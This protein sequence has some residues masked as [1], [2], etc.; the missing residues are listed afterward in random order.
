VGGCME[1]W[2]VKCEGG[3]VG[4]WMDYT[5]MDN[6][7]PVNHILKRPIVSDTEN[8]DSTMNSSVYYWCKI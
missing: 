8:Y 2:V 3:W 6:I 4:V 5:Y 7:Y 1:G